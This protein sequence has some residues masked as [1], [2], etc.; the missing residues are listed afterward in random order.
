MTGDPEDRRK[1]RSSAFVVQQ[2]N[3]ISG[4]RDCRRFQYRSRLTRLTSRRG[5]RNLDEFSRFHVV[6][7]AVYRNVIGNQCM[8]PDT[9]DIL[10][11]LRVVGEC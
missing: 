9:Q 1:G 10:D 8:V 5:F 3:G 2:C 6:N 7:I 11:T 4:R